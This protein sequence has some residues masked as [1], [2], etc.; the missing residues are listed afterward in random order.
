MMLFM[1]TSR[2]D[3]TSGT[4]GNDSLR[5]DV[6]SGR[7][8]NR[9]KISA[10]CGCARGETPPPDKNRRSGIAGEQIKIHKIAGV[11]PRIR[12]MMPKRNTNAAADGSGEWGHA[13]C[14]AQRSA[15]N[16]GR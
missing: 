1:V 15:K 6:L 3:V 10:R 13:A 8:L 4:D 7:M 9:W 12:E 11:R 2:C 5:R 16:G 14:G